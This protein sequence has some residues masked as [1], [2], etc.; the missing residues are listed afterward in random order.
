M[1]LVHIFKYALLTKGSLTKGSVAYS[2]ST[3]SFARVWSKP[4]VCAAMAAL[5]IELLN[6]FIYKILFENLTHYLEPLGKVVELDLKKFFYVRVTPFFH[7][8]IKNFRAIS[9]FTFFTKRVQNF[10]F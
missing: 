5:A 3:I 9:S 1:F 2:G 4:S 7:T 10:Q 8:I 6:K